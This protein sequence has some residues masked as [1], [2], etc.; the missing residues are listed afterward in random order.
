MWYNFCLPQVKRASLVD[1]RSAVNDVKFAPRHLGL[2]LVRICYVVKPLW[3]CSRPLRRGLSRSMPFCNGNC[4]ALGK[5]DLVSFPYLHC[6]W[7][8]FYSLSYSR[9]P[10]YSYSINCLLPPFTYEGFL[11]H[12][13]PVEDIWGTRRDEPQSVDPQCENYVASQTLASR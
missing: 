7:T 8:V 5:W 11:F 4:R 10:L 9:F 6:M 12:W 13:W 2:Q 1:S 3:S